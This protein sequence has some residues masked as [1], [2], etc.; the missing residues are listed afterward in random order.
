ML[1]RGEHG[2][3][4]DFRTGARRGGN[5][6]ERRGRFGQRLAATDDFDVVKQIAVVGHHGG[7]G[8]AGVQHAA[9]AKADDQIAILP[10]SQGRAAADGFQIGFAGHG[11][12]RRADAGLPQPLQQ[13]LRAAESRPVTTRA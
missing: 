4:R 1:R 2:V 10:A 8:L 6:Q 3:A 13:R 7:D 5:G 11:K 12:N 9:A